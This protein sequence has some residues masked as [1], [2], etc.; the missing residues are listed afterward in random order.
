MPT[1]TRS[2]RAI[3]IVRVSQTK[4]REGDSFHSPGT[5]R[6]RIGDT[7][8]RNGWRLLEVHEELDVSGGKSLD[9][10]PGLRAAVEAIEARRADVLAV[11]YLD[12]L[13]RDPR[14]RDEVVDRVEAAGGEVWTVDMGR[15]TNGTAAE[16]LTGTMASAVHRY[17]RRVAAERSREAQARAVSR[18]VIP[19]PN[20]PPGYRR[21]DDGRLEPDPKIAPI[22]A[23]AFRMRAE[24]A[25]LMAV[26]DYL[27]SQGVKRSFHGVCSLLSSRIVLGE[28]R[29]GD[30]ANP[31]A[32]EPIVSREVWQA[33]QASHVLPH[34]RR[35]LRKPG[36]LRDAPEHA[37][38]ARHGRRGRRPHK[39][40]AAA[41]R[42]S[43]AAVRPR[44]AAP[45][46]TRRAASS[47]RRAATRTGRR[48][49]A[50]HR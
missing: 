50:S 18:G 43:L 27:A 11:A 17:V 41:D 48:P 25:T 22:V 5:Q 37:D 12:R 35:R 44:G 31:D 15:Q 14:V 38:T 28:I 4:G 3:G 34:Q 21:G 47:P 42:H 26:R 32:H 24:G 13:T 7:C 2:R 16:Q 30:L 29:F 46:A 8:D 9:A 40:A 20:V 1:T 23:E 19:F 33:V 49:D 36:A 10:R 39:G 45:P 6:D